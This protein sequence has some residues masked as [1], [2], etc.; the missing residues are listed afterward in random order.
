MTFG[1]ELSPI[2]RE[3]L[4]GIRRIGYHVYAWPHYNVAGYELDIAFPDEKLDVECDGKYWH[5]RH[6]ERDA[7]RDL[8]LT[9]WGWTVL[10]F[11]GTR[12]HRD[13]EGCVAEVDAKLAT[14]RSRRQHDRSR[15]I[16]SRGGQD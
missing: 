16:T 13:I 8:D 9:S 12:I 1:T 15:G 2:E 10:R 7:R 11:S 5:M 3:M 6:P 4:E 14:L